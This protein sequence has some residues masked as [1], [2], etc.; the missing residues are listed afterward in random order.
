MNKEQVE[1]ENK[2]EIAMRAIDASKSDLPVTALLLFER[3]RAR[4]RLTPYQS[5]LYAESLRIIG[6]S[7]EALEVLEGLLGESLPWKKAWLVHLRLGMMKEQMG[8]VDEALDSF[9]VAARLNPS[10]TVPWIFLGGRLALSERFD[11]AIDAYRCGLGAHGDLEEVHLNLGYV[12]RAAGRMN[13][14]RDA[15]RSALAIDPT[16]DEAQNALRDVDSAL[17]VIHED[18][19]EEG[20]RENGPGH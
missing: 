15:F 3:L 8:K 7:H 2:C 12:L 4:G 14:A 10:S 13:E 18:A 17:A 6:R 5:Y 1:G 19:R 9:R 11:E 20:A 16:Y